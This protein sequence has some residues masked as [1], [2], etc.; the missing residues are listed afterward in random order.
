MIRRYAASAAVAGLALLAPPA[1]A[2]A[3]VCRT[4]PDNC[5][6]VAVEIVFNVYEAADREADDALDRLP[7]VTIAP[8]PTLV[9]VPK[10]DVFNQVCV[11]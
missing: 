5:P 3:D 6:E 8:L 2:H 10:N 7:T 11:F 1:P 9:C 4:G